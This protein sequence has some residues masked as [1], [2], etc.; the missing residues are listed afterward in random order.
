[1]NFKKIF[2][3]SIFVLIFSSLAFAGGKYTK[4]SFVSSIPTD[5][6]MGNSVMTLIDLPA[7]TTTSILATTSISTATLVASGT[8][9]T[10]I[11]GDITDVVFPRNLTVD[12]SFDSGESTTTVSGT[13]VITGNNQFGKS[14]TEGIAISTNSATGAVGWSTI[15]QVAFSNVTISGASEANA[16]LSIGTGNKIALSNNIQNTSDFLKVIEAGSTSTTYTGT[17]AY[18]TIAFATDPDG[19][20]DYYIYFINRSN[21]ARYKY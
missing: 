13:L 14:T 10:L 4:R 11:S 6:N 12:V 8:S 15:T 5:V 7:A 20:N 19:S 17:T 3:A 16:K 9:Y 1:M 18:D 2:L 21:T